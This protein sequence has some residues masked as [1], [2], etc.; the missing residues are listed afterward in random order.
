M[1]NGGVAEVEEPDALGA[2]GRGEREAEAAELALGVEHDDGGVVVAQVAEV[3]AQHRGGLA[4]A[5]AADEQRA[6]A[7][8]RRGGSAPAPLLARSTGSSG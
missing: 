5:L 2:V 8:G 3:E 6:V 4:R 1:P 7:C